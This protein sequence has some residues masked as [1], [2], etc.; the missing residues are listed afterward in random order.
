MP[1]RRIE[2]VRKRDGRVET[3]D[4]AKIAAAIYRAACAAGQDNRYL[5]ND[6]AGAVTTYLERYHGRDVPEATEIQSMVERIL[7]ETGHADI[8]KAFIRYQER[9]LPAAEPAAPAG[10]LFPAEPVL[11]DAASRDE[12]S[13]WGR[14][15]I[16][17]A[18]VKEAGLEEALAR[19]IATAVEAKIFLAGHRRVSTSLIREM[20]NQELLA[21]GLHVKLRKQLVV[22]LPKYDLDR[23][24]RPE[25]AAAAARA[26]DPE[27][28]CRTIGETTMRQYALQEV[29]SRDVADA[30]VE[31][32][33]HVHHLE[34]PLKQW[35]IAPSV[36]SVRRAGVRAP[37]L[38]GA[39][40]NGRALTAHLVAL[41]REQGP[42]TAEAVE[43]AHLN[44]Q[45]AALPGDP[46]EE[47]DGL[48]GALAGF[49]AAPAVDA[50]LPAYLRPQLGEAEE[51]V[52][53]FAVEMLRA[54][55]GSGIAVD[56]YVGEGASAAALREACR[57]AAE[58]GRVRFVFERGA[59]PAPRYSRW[60]AGEG[61]WSAVQAVTINLPQAFHRAERGGDFYAELELAIDAAVKAH[62]QKRQI[63]KRTARGPEADHLV[64]LAG[65]PEAA[66]LMSG[67]D[68]STDDAAFR[69]SLRIVSYLYFRAREE[70][71]KHGLRLSIQ[72][73]ADAGAC[74]RLNRI[75]RQLFPRARGLEGSYT[76]GGR[77]PAGTTLGPAATIEAEARFHTLIP[78]G[79]ATIR[80]AE[81]SSLSPGALLDLVERAFRTTLAAQLVV[82]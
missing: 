28:M 1:H 69:L 38:D 42:W 52:T 49:A 43:L 6:L 3:F 23:M 45:Y 37:L 47:A 76:P 41:L 63:Q 4:E 55:R 44:S 24:V 31:G 71:A 36:E 22:G 25:D 30:H 20:V 57:L 74:E 54:A 81:R 78:S 51:R 66:T 2:S 61:P 8:A 67:R 35:W 13:A 59:A 5:A 40:R 68:P 73:A 60:S 64:G 34:Y 32:R 58:R 9:A 27:R 26:I 14:E 50:G 75:D 7:L 48:F 29:Y 56:C 70:S 11:V 79:A 53:A 10:E 21:R 46:A 15:R 77:L 16:S 12:V 33:I 17:A 80:A 18:L 62:L 72:D 39:P 82:E 19:D 65:L